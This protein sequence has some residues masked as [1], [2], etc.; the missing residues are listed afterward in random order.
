MDYYQE[1]FGS[2]EPHRDPDAAVKFAL[3]CLLLSGK[4]GWLQDVLDARS[5]TL[6]IAAEPGWQLERRNARV[7]DPTVYGGW[8][9][10]AEFRAYVDPDEFELAHPEAFYDART[11]AGFVWVALAV[12]G[13]RHPE[14]MPLVARLLDL[15][16]KRPAPE[17][18][19]VG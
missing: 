5:D 12:Y 18:A 16:P 1:A 6:S 14:D 15:L 3:D 19:E 4:V 2:F 11:F 9:D 13:R 17:A 7:S 8:P 10:S